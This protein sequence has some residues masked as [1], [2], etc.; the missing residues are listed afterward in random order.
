MIMGMT[1]VM[2][3][4]RGRCTSTATSTPLG[5]AILKLEMM[6]KEV[7]RM[8]SRRK[9]LLQKILHNHNNKKMK[10]L[11]IKT[12]LSRPPPVRLPHPPRSQ[13]RQQ[14][15]KRRAQRTSGWRRRR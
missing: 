4:R 5:L 10:R 6:E 13:Q 14:M 7:L 3:W 12:R 2:Q 1:M 8:K 15:C 9:Q 11:G